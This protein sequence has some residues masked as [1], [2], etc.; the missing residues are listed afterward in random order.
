MWKYS[1]YQNFSGSFK[2][3]LCL[4]WPLSGCSEQ[5]FR[6]SSPLRADMH[7]SCFL[8]RFWSLW[9]KYQPNN[10]KGVIIATA[11]G[12]TGKKKMTFGILRAWKLFTSLVLKMKFKDSWKKY[13]YW[14]CLVPL[15]YFVY[16]LFRVFTL[17]CT[18]FF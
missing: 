5:L 6:W 2:Q 17:W 3:P 1:A 12:T 16:L 7:F 18:T 13:H 15:L 14:S 4:M 10:G 8:Y 11:T 9:H